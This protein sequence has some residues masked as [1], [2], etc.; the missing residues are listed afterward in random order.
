MIY[1][2]ILPIRTGGKISISISSAS[3]DKSICQRL[4]IANL[5]VKGCGGSVSDGREKSSR[6]F[7]R[8]LQ[9][10]FRVKDR[11]CSTTNCSILSIPMWDV[12]PMIYVT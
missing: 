5:F 4:R 11:C 8:E 3:V 2:V 1:L 9:L 12:E 10:D 7:L 6:I